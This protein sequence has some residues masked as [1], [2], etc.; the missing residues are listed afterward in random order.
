MNGLVPYVD[1]ADDS[2]G[3][4]LWL[5]YVIG[6]IFLFVNLLTGKIIIGFLI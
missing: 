5:I 3:P 6:L 4:L 2:K 1:F